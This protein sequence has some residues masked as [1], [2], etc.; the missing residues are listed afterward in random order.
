MRHIGIALAWLLLPLAALADPVPEPRLPPPWRVRLGLGLQQIDA[1]AYNDVA[2]L[3]GYDG[4]SVAQQVRF[5]AVAPLSDRVRVGPRA[6]FAHAD[7]GTVAK[8]TLALSAWQIGGVVDV[9]AGQL[10]N[11][12]RKDDHGLVSLEIGGGAARSAIDLRGAAVTAIVPVAWAAVRF[13]YVNRWGFS[14]WFGG[15]WQPWSSTGPEQNGVNLT[16]LDLGFAMEVLP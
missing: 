14:F 15:Q 11:A 3:W 16:G 1:K 10:P 8:G 5:D 4:F 12:R 2:Q 7:G 9:V 13:G 6:A